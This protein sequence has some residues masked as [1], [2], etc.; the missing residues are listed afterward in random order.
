[1]DNVANAGKHG[2][3]DS[4]KDGPISV[5]ELSAMTPI[6]VAV[7]GSVASEP[8]GVSPVAAFGTETFVE[9]I[10]AD[11]RTF[12]AWRLIDQVRLMWEGED[13]KFGLF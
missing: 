12:P 9:V 1:M 10:V 7:G 2:A 4:T 8:L 13:Q 5:A 3:K 11:G 6:A